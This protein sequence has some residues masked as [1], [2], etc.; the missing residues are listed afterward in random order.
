[1]L[2]EKGLK[3]TVEDSKSFQANAFIQR[4][5]F[6]Q[7]EIDASSD[8]SEVSFRLYMPSLIDCLG[9]FGLHQQADAVLCLKYSDSRY[10]SLCWLGCN[11]FGRERSRGCR[12][13]DQRRERRICAR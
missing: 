6:Q 8:S 13:G 10:V 12:L 2:E 7:Y 4:E 5:L 3:L 11:R 9:L 1:M